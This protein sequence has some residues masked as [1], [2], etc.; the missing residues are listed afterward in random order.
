MAESESVQIAKNELA[1]VIRNP[2]NPN[3]FMS[4]NPVGRLVEVFIVDERIA[5]SQDAV[6]VLEVG[7]SMYSPQ[8]Y[9]PKKDVPE[10]LV[11]IEKTSHCPLKG[12]A[13]YYAFMGNEIAWA[14]EDHLEFAQDLAELVA[15]WPNKVRI[16]IGV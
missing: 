3:H 13:S 9:L 10:S 16:E 8:L 2:N 14:Y 12:D 11:K 7:K 5:S 15:F 1:G 4:I 6:W